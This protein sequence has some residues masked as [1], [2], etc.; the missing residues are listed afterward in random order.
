MVNTE[1]LKLQNQLLLELTKNNA[2]NRGETESLFKQITELGATTLK[3]QR[4]SIWIFR[5]NK[6][7]IECIDLYEAD[8]QTHSKGQLLFSKNFQKY[9]EYI[10]NERFLS[11]NNVYENPNT[12]ELSEYYLKPAGIVSMLDAPIRKMGEIYGIICFEHTSTLREWSIEEQNFAASLADIISGIFESDAR[13]KAELELKKLNEQ[14]EKKVEEKTLEVKKTL[15]EIQYLKEQ[16]DTDYYLTSLLIQPLSKTKMNL[17]CL[18]DIQSIIK[19]KK[20]FK[21][22]NHEYQIGGDFVFSEIVYLNNEPNIFLINADAMGKSLQGASGILVLGSVLRSI[23]FTINKTKIKSPSSFLIYLYK[24]F[25]KIFLSF[26]GAINISICMVM[27]SSNGNAYFLS[28]GHPKP[29]IYRNHK[30]KLI[31]IPVIPKIGT[32]ENIPIYSKI[33]LKKTKIKKND[34]LILTS[35]GREYFE[36]NHN[37]DEFFYLEDKEF[38]KIVETSNGNIEEIYNKL[39]KKGKFLDDF[40]IISIKIN[41]DFDYKAMYFSSLKM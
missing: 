1:F 35:D 21:Y 22:K 7:S 19:Q 10:S 2:I 3:V 41:R 36:R 26:D 11:A 30:A 40:S 31:S 14:L 27:I 5:E 25:Y 18:C 29:V 34:I 15:K 6:E 32:K 20:I 24:K 33:P 8:K 13:R 38:L 39:S 17:D 28:T 4:C 23:L 16:Q 37:S 12:V 9:F